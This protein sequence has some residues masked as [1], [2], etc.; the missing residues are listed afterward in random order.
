MSS[1]DRLIPLSRLRTARVENGVASPRLG[2]K[3]F[4]YGAVHALVDA[5]TVTLLFAALTLNAFPPLAA[6]D[7]IILYNA[8]AFAT[9][10]VIGLIT[11]LVKKPKIVFTV[12]IGLVL[13]SFFFFGSLPWIA[14]ALAALGNAFFHVGA[15]VIAF[16]FTP[17]RA[18]GPGIFVGPGALGLGAGTFLGKS[19]I[20]P[21]IPFAALLLAAGIALWLVKAP[22]TYSEREKLKISARLP[23]LALGVFLVLIFARGFVGVTSGFTLPKGILTLVLVSLAAAAGKMLGGLAADRWGWLK[24]TAGAVAASAP[25]LAFTGG[26]VWV[27][28]AG[29]LLFQAAMPV[30]L[31]AA[32]GIM[33]RTPG[34]AFGLNCLMLFA[35][36]FVDYSP[37][38]YDFYHPLFT[39]AA[40]AVTALLLAGGLALLSG[41][42]RPGAGNRGNTAR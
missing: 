2:Y 12:G 20:F 5:A 24:V 37:L 19:G 14:I 32:A 9:Q 4:V 30:T 23:A 41:R 35:G 15:G 42:L 21:I 33:P 7:A 25:L 29:V 16:F 8:L 6:R 17:G 40:V 26:V 18:S 27:G 1:G 11:D 39:L 34:L 38:R 28:A 31:T 3:P 36:G 10:P 13:A 22:P